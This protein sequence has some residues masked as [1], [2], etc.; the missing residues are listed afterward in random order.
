MIEPPRVNMLVHE[1]VRLAIL[2]ALSE[3]EYYFTALVRRLR[4]VSKGNLSNHL[5]ELVNACYVSRR[6]DEGQTAFCITEAGRLALAAWSAELRR[7][8]EAL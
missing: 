8:R 5:H 3:R 2:L 1:P 7:F 4:T 6:I